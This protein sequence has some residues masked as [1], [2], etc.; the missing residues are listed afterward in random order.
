MWKAVVSNRYSHK[1][2][3]RRG[4]ASV[5]DSCKVEGFLVNS[6]QVE[7]EPGRSHAMSEPPRLS[8]SVEKGGV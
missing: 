5:I 1:V 6:T 3:V 4:G 7:L 8:L 2:L